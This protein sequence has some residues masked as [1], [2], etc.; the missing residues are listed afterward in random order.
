MYTDLAKLYNKRLPLCLEKFQVGKKRNFWMRQEQLKSCEMFS[1]SQ[2][3]CARA[4]CLFCDQTS[5]ASV[6]WARGRDLTVVGSSLGKIVKSSVFALL[7]P[8]SLSCGFA[9]LWN[10]LPSNTS[11]VTQCPNLLLQNLFSK[12]T[13]LHLMIYFH[14]QPNAMATEWI[15]LQL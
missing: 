4:W 15:F 2:N 10:T 14:W 9:V 3:Q 6:P 8:T 13:L 12:G 5:P 7:A 11:S 1:K